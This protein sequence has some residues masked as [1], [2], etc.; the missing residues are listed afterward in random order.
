MKVLVVGNGGR[1]HA[2]DFEEL[3]EERKAADAAEEDR[4]LYVAL[5]RPT[6]VL[7]TFDIGGEGAW[8]SALRD[9]PASVGRDR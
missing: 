8:R 2:L 6:Q 9:I 4:V 7:V 5:T 3:R 1:E